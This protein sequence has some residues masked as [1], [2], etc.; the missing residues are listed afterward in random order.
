MRYLTVKINKKHVAKGVFSKG[1]KNRLKAFNREHKKAYLVH[2][3]WSRL[4][5]F[6]VITVVFAKP[7]YFQTFYLKV[8]RME[9]A[10]FKTLSNI[11]THKLCFRKRMSLARTVISNNLLLSFNRG[12]YR[13]SSP[14]NYYISS[15]F[16]TRDVFSEPQGS[17]AIIFFPFLVLSQFQC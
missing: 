7:Y 1:F 4:S 8:I 10:I 14:L 15:I 6:L 3:A 12:N 16:T 2:I 5:L 11:Y 17:T 9:F 13:I